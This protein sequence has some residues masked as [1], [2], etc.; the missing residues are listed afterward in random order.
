MDNPYYIPKDIDR[1]IPFLMWEM[2]DMGVATGAFMIG[3]V[4]EQFLVGVVLM[5]FWM[6]FSKQMAAKSKRG[7]MQHILWRNGVNLDTVMRK[8]AQDP[9][10]IEYH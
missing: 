4:L 9:F 1:P 6:W 2:K 7:A 5:L 3:M 8:H 10:V